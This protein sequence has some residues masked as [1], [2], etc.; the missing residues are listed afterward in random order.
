[1]VDKRGRRWI[2]ESQR[3][4][5]DST[6][7]CD[8]STWHYGIQYGV[9]YSQTLDS[10]K[11]ATIRLENDTRQGFG[12]KLKLLRRGDAPRPSLIAKRTVAPYQAIGKN[13]YQIFRP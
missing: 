3:H 10:E 2:Y 1:M 13:S 4:V 12:N 11:W 5:M 7:L 6:N 8:W 9:Q